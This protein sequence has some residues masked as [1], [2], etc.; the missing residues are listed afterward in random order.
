MSLT[1]IKYTLQSGPGGFE[2]TPDTSRF[3]DAKLVAPQPRNLGSFEGE[4]RRN[5]HGY[6]ES[7]SATQAMLSLIAITFTLVGAVCLA[8]GLFPEAF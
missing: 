1:L 8:F 4:R 7:Y 2:A 5:S 3:A 6:D